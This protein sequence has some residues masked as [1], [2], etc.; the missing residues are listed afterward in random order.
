MQKSKTKQGY[1][2]SNNIQIGKYIMIRSDLP[3]ENMGGLIF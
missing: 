1:K 3:Y 2:N